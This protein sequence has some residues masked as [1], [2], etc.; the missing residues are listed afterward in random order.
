MYV[1]QPAEKFGRRLST[2]N[3]SVSCA[4]D[5][6]FISTY[7]VVTLQYVYGPLCSVLCCVFSLQLGVA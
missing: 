7:F 5:L 4:V 2:K 6:Y 1:T 3:F